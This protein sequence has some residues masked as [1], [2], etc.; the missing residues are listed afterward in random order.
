MSL[1]SNPVRCESDQVGD[2]RLRISFGK[3]AFIDP[4]AFAQ[5]I[6]SLEGF[7]VDGNSVFQ[8]SN[9]MR[10]AAV[11]LPHDGSK[12]GFQE[13]L[14]KLRL[15]QEAFRGSAMFKP[16]TSCTLDTGS[17]SELKAFRYSTSESQQAGQEP[18]FQRLE[19]SN[20]HSLDP[21]TFVQYVRSALPAVD[22]KSLLYEFE[23]NTDGVFKDAAVII[24]QLADI[25]TDK[26]FRITFVP[27]KYDGSGSL[28]TME[29]TLRNADMFGPDSSAQLTYMTMIGESIVSKRI[30]EWH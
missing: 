6:L 20:L 30:D 15:V 12:A 5:L 2:H 8:F 4:S 7:K 17:G 21:L 14:Q 29:K 19:F 1:S 22:H 26:D 25:K 13:G 3:F 23:V 24:A 18:T 11:T 9:D 27:R 10:S 28:K 16:L